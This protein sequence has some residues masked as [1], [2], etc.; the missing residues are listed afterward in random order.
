MVLQHGRGEIRNM[1][2]LRYKGRLLI[3]QTIDKAF[4]INNK[5]LCGYLGAE[6]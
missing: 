1:F 3:N 5:P 6:W 2:N 4:I